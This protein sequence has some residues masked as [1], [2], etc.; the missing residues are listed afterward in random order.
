MPSFWREP[1]G[2]HAYV[3]S[4]ISLIITLIAGIGGIAAYYKLNSS[5]ILV[6]GLENMVD[7][8]SSA[9][10]LWRFYLP[11]SSDPAEEARLLSR[12]K[13]ASVGISI[14]FVMLGFGTILTASEDFEA[15]EEQLENL[16]VLFY[17]SF[18][19]IIIFGSFAICKLQF[20]RKL[21]SSS[22]K[23]DG[24]ISGL[25]TVL[26]ISLFIN[27]ILT[28][29]SHGHLWWLDPLIALFCG[30][31]SFIYGMW[32]VYKAYVREGIPICTCGWWLYGYNPNDELDVEMKSSPA[33]STPD[34]MGSSSPT[35]AGPTST[36]MERINEMEM[37]IGDDA[38]DEIVLT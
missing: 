34:S 29:A 19:S 11:A 30:I 3:L 17:L 8:I 18:F 6:Y 33:P 13:R 22:L 25:G 5:L 27:T 14:V 21:N 36:R 15:G 1:T 35:S 32:G 16:D 38:V 28:K 24:I 37:N 31:G 10:V 20:A 9:I 7:F 12:E 4:W 2:F 26:S 23:K